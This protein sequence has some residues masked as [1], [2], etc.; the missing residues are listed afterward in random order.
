MPISL[1]PGNRFP[2]V[3]DCD[4]DKPA[5]SRPTFYVLSQ[6]MRGHQSILEAIDYRHKPEVTV[7]Q[8]FNCACDKLNEVI[9]GW[10]NMGEFVFGRAKFREMFVE[11]L[12][13]N[14]P[15]GTGLADN[16]VV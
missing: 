11:N 10:S 15:V 16:Q 5:E 4:A 1:E 7:E 14:N 8:V 9:V 12:V 2:V 3:L 6:T 13:N